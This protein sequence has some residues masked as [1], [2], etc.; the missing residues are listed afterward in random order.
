LTFVVWTTKNAS[1]WGNA[2]KSRKIHFLKK[3]RD[4]CQG[5]NKS[6]VSD[7]NSVGTVMEIQINPR[8]SHK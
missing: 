4:K 1:K 8:H 5:S 6:K 3:E 7:R 2:R